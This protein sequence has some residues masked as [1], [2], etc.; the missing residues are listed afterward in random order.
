[1]RMCDQITVNARRSVLLVSRDSERPAPVSKVKVDLL[2]LFACA[3]E[4]KRSAGEETRRALVRALNS[5]DKCA[6][7]VA[8]AF[9]GM[10]L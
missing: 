9:L 1:M 10:V 6:R 5:T 8:S 2:F 7:R 3:I 4:W